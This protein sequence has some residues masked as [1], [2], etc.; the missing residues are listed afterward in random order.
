MQNRAVL[1]VVDLIFL[2][3]M[4]IRI[5]RS[6]IMRSELLIS[7]IEYCIFRE[8]RTTP[9][10]RR[11]SSEFERSRERDRTS[12]EDQRR[13]SRSRSPLRNGQH[14]RREYGLKP[15]SAFNN[16]HHD[17]NE[18]RVK[19]ERRDDDVTI[20]GSIEREKRND[21]LTHG[22]PVSHPLS[23]SSM[24]ADPNRRL[25]TPYAG[26]ASERPPNASLW[27]PLTDR[28]D[29]NRH[30]LELQQELERERE[31]EL[32]RRFRPVPGHPMLEHDRLKEQH[33]IFMRERE[34]EIQRE[35]QE[36]AIRDYEMRSRIDLMHQYEREREHFDRSKI[37]PPLRP[38]HFTPTA[39]GSIHFPGPRG[40]PNVV[41][42]NS[43]N[44]SKNSS[45]A[46]SVGAP[47]PLIPSS[48]NALNNSH[49]HSNSPTMNGPTKSKSNSPLELASKERR[50]ANETRTNEIETK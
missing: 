42:H 19:D 26:L 16:L 33:D 49:S 37:P 9:V 35:L 25:L 30:R 44:T 14:E 34:R 28:I 20:V 4:L 43:H 40:S 13:R 17:K 1:E 24:L 12:Y 22:L 3:L 21:F 23:A 32:L 50:E 31:R 45:P 8:R 41:N 39:S 18:L 2:I 48:A 38:D 6:D 7:N 27:N 15:D 29:V 47:P 5:I 36:R 46:T 10:D 11:P